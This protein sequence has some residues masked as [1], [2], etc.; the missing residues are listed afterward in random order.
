MRI[1]QL[2]AFF[3]TI[4]APPPPTFTADIVLLTEGYQAAMSV[5]RDPEWTDEEFRDKQQLAAQIY[6]VSKPW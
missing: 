5:V 4:S 3:D 6:W 1:P 2:L